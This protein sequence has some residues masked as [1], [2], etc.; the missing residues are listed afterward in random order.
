MV[1]IIIDPAYRYTITRPKGPEMRTNSP[2]VTKIPMP[3]EP[4]I[5]M[6]LLGAQQLLYNKGSN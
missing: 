5:P 3:D 2:D 4:E 1:G 6:P